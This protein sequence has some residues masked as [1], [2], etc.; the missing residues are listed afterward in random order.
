MR[1]FLRGQ[2]IYDSHLRPDLIACQPAFEYKCAE[3][4]SIAIEVL[5]D[6]FFGEGVA[7]GDADVEGLRTE[8][9]A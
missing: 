6:P 1:P 8:A 2:P 7:I 5:I 4:V 3:E 9:V